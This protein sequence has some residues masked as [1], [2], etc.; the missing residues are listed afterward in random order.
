MEIIELNLGN[1]NENEVDIITNKVRVIIFDD[2]NNIILTKYAD[3]FMFPGGKVNKDESNIEALIREVQEELGIDVS[4]C[5]IIPFIEFNNYL[6]N[7]PKVENNQRINKLNRTIYYL[8]KTNIKI[9]DKNKNLTEREIK[10]NFSTLN[11]QL[12]DAIEIVKNY[13]SNNPRNIY[14]KEE[15]IIIMEKIINK[16]EK[17]KIRIKNK[18]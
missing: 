17:K 2:D 6:N 4:K 12:N 8:I 10:N 3:M 16:K 11:L 13:K 9:N 15:V 18:E 5:N 14:F 7:Y 1:I